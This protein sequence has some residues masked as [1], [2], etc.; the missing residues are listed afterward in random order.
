MTNPDNKPVQPKKFCSRKKLLLLC[1]I[2]VVVVVYLTSSNLFRR[3][4]HYRPNPESEVVPHHY[5]GYKNLTPYPIHSSE[6]PCEDKDWHSQRYDILNNDSIVIIH[7]QKTG[8]SDFLRH[9]VTVQRDDKYL[10]QLPDYMILRIEKRMS[11]PKGKQRVFCPK[12]KSDPDSRQWLLSAKTLGWKCGVHPSFTEYKNCEH[13]LDIGQGNQFSKYRY[14]TILRNPILRFLSEFEHVSRGAHWSSRK[15]CKG[16]KVTDSDMPP[17]YPGFYD[18]KK[19]PSLTL[20]DFLACESNWARNRQVMWLADL[21]TVG[22]FDPNIENRDERLLASAKCNLEK[23]SFFGLTEYQDETTFMFEKVFN[24]T[25]SSPPEQYNMTYLHTAPILKD[26]WRRND[27]YNKIVSAN[28]L[29]MKLYEHALRLF[30]R[31]AKAFGLTMDLQ[32][33]DKNVHA[34][35]NFDINMTAQKFTKGIFDLT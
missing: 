25:F 6:T 1:I 22:C 26:I 34:I 33:V 11:L 21:E 18:G 7:I 32:K 17:C 24:V 15:K 20:T 31:R 3:I 2:L 10:C 35:H 12:Q 27:L 30:A 19:W 9:L 28:H 14:V 5:I 8:G 23:M 29:D 13:N 4:T 16:K